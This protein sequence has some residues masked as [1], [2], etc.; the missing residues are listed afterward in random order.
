MITYTADGLKAILDSHMGWLGG[1]GGQWAD[2]RGADLTGAILRGAHLSYADLTGSNLSDTNLRGVNLSCAD[3]TGANLCNSKLIG[4][5]LLYA[6]GNGREVMSSYIHPWRVVHTK[7][8][9]AIG[10]EQHS[11]SE[12]LGFTDDQISEMDPHALK[13][14]KEWK[15]KLIEV[16]IF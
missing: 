15:P 5:N 6:V 1:N 7:D 14:W 2:L 10:C 4:A 11:K 3:L 16:G 8:I 12:W 13:W 9:V